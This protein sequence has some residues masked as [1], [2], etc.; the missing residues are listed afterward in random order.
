[1]LYMRWRMVSFVLKK[2]V[3]LFGNKK[4]YVEPDVTSQDEWIDVIEVETDVSQN[5]NSLPF[6]D[7]VEVGNEVEEIG[8]LEDENGEELED[9]KNKTPW[10]NFAIYCDNLVKIFKS[11]E[12]EVMALQGLELEVKRGE[13]MAIIGK[14]GSGKS[15]LMNLIGGLETPTLGRIYV[16]G[17]NLA[18][19]P[20]K[21]KTNYRR[22][23]IGFVWQKSERN[24]LQYLTAVE[25]VMMP[26][27]F[28]KKTEEEKRQRAEELLEMVGM[29]HRKM[30]FP[31]QMSGGEQQ[32]VAI[33]VALANNPQILLADEPTGAVDSRTSS[34]IQDL[35][36]ELNRKLNLTIIIVTHDIKLAH[37]VDRVVMISDGKISSEKVLKQEYREKIDAMASDQDKDDAMDENS[38]EEYSVLDKANRVQLTK[39]MLSEAGIDGNKVKIHVENGKVVISS[40]ES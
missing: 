4:E 13:F 34:D 39:D 12:I 20:E 10:E 7:Q 33:A 21:E 35:F 2:K 22:N 26:M 31:T 28:T 23:V 37:K 24:L 29:G 9:G 8:A 15:T 19:M 36:R 14:S 25:N 6:S 27:N 17:N 11:D 16:E 3:R 18:D 32:R 38:H 5:E 40:K 1:M 30:S